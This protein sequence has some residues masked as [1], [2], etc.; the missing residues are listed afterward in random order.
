MLNYFRQ[1]FQPVCL[2][3]PVR[4]TILGEFSPCSLITSCSLNRYYRVL[5]S[6]VRGRFRKI[7]WPSQNIWTLI[8]YKTIHCA[9]WDKKDYKTIKYNKDIFKDWNKILNQWSA[10]KTAEKSKSTN[11][12]FIASKGQLI[13]KGLFAIL[14]FLQKMNKTIQS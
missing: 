6:K 8:S 12:K 13:S 11:S 14:E 7:L 10:I 1:K 5:Q 3:H 4:L 2:I 9:L